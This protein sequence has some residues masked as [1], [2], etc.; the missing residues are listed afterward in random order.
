[1]SRGR[2]NL[3]KSVSSCPTP[4]SL[5]TSLASENARQ[6][7]TVMNQATKDQHHREFAAPGAGLGVALDA[8]LGAVLPAAAGMDVVLGVDVVL[9]MDVVGA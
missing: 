9:G 1:M 8:V 7:V 2:E 6:L 5:P 4:F 3:Q